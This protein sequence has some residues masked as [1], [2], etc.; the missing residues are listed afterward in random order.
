MTKKTL[1]HK[2][3]AQLSNFIE[4]ADISKSQTYQNALYIEDTQ[5]LDAYCSSLQE[6]N[7]WIAID[8]EFVRVD[9]YYP[10]LSLVQI[11]DSNLNL[12]IID[13]LAIKQ[14]VL[15][16]KQLP[17]FSETNFDL[18]QN[19]KHHG[20]NPLL[21]ILVNPAICKVFHSARQ[22]LEVLYLIAGI[23]P[24]NIFDTQ[25]AA[26]FFGQGDLAGFARVIQSELGLTLPKSQTRTNWH[27]RPL[28][29]NQISYALDDVYYL[30]QLF[31]SYQTKLSS[32]QKLAINEDCESLLDSKLYQTKP[33]EAWLKI[34]GGKNLK[35]KQL[36][37][38]RTLAEWREHFAIEHN[39]PK[40]WT[41]SD[42][43]ILHIAKRP[44]KTAQAL[45][46]VPNIKASSVKEF[47]EKWVSLIDEVFTA[48]PENYP[49]PTPKD[50]SPT[51]QEEI[52]LQVL[53]AMA[54]QIS[55]D[56]NITPTN[57]VQKTHLLSFIRE[58]NPALTEQKDS[59][60]LLINR[61]W[62]KYLF[63]DLAEQFLNNE[64]SFSCDKHSLKLTRI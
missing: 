58:K 42:E 6:N 60:L 9:T 11:A 23:L 31:K 18:E 16:K 37:I 22:D 14:D 57:L 43:V 35:P 50:K 8:T 45:Y 40:K 47:G 7:E 49:N 44:P 30:A 39:Q 28:T 48:S 25:L 4:L 20:L 19:K 21:E 15:Q 1:D 64:L 27:A 59:K 46:K 54:Q 12:A 41:I 52:L 32:Q 63:F 51:A 56:A 34:K 3:T 10:E 29:E 61:G 33:N 55:I 13:P 5:T 38:V 62:R 36:A 2:D 26:I 17:S 53:L 24:Q